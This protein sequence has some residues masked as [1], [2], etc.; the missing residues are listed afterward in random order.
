MDRIIIRI[1]LIVIIMQMIMAMM[2]LLQRI[3][4]RNSMS[5]FYDKNAFWTIIVIN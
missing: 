1:V 2:S 4:C 3:V 5:Q